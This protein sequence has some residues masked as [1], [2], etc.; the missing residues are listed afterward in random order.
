MTLSISNLC[1]HDLIKNWNMFCK[2]SEIEIVS[3]ETENRI[4]F[5]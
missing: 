1:D 2:K 4:S 5:L 3:S